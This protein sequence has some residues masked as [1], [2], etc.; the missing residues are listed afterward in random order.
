MKE[1]KL[2]SI[3]ALESLKETTSN[4]ITNLQTINASLRSELDKTKTDKANAIET[5]ARAENII[6]NLKLT[7]AKEVASLE[8]E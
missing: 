5:A 7:T 1:D 6:H 4:Q 8:N 2:A 3:K